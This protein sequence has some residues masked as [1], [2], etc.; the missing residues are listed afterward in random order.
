MS[1]IKAASAFFANSLL[2]LYSQRVL[3]PGRGLPIPSGGSSGSCRVGCGGSQGV[4]GWAQPANSSS[5]AIPWAPGQGCYP[6][7]GQLGERA[8]CTRDLARNQHTLCLPRSLCVDVQEHP[9]VPPRCA[10]SAKVRDQQKPHEGLQ[11]VKGVLPW[12]LEKDRD[13]KEHILSVTRKQVTLLLKTQ[14]RQCLFSLVC[15]LSQ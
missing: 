14:H 4:G 10:S 13:Y 1:E 2:G 15:V 12:K 6:H 11:T 9:G 7:D 8:T 5:P 3:W